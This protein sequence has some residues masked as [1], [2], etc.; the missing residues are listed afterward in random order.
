[1]IGHGNCPHCKADLNGGSIWQHFMDKLGD[2]AEATRIASMYGATRTEGQWGRQLAIY[3]ME[4]DRSMA[5]KCP[6]C[7]G[8]WPR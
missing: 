3:D 6:D 1:M 4:R 5:F 8:E 7:E 2:E